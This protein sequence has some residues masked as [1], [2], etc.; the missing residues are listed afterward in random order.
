MRLTTPTAWRYGSPCSMPP[1]AVNAFNSLVHKI[2]GQSELSWS[3][4]EPFEAKFSG[5]YSRTSSE[6]WGRRG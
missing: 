3:I 4:F 5:G 2:A 6:S 1:A